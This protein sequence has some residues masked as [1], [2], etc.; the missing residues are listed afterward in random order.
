MEDN[1]KKKYSQKKF[2]FQFKNVKYDCFVEYKTHKANIIITDSETN[3]KVFAFIRPQKSFDETILY[4]NKE[5]R[6]LV[7]EAI[8]ATARGRFEALVGYNYS[9]ELNI[10]LDSIKSYGSDILGIMNINKS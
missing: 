1:D 6:K 8:N 3:K 10:L 9:L 2:N 4:V 5:D 7:D